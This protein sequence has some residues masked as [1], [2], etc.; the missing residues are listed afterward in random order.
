MGLVNKVIKRAL[1]YA[2]AHPPSSPEA[3]E[4]TERAKRSVAIS[5]AALD[6]AASSADDS[7]A[8]AVLRSEVTDRGAVVRDAID[9]LAN[10]RDNY[11]YDRAFRLLTAAVDGGPVRPIDSAVRDLFLGEQQLG[12]LPLED[13][14]ASLARTEP[15]L[16]DVEREIV[17]QRSSFEHAESQ[18][19]ARRVIANRIERLVGFGARRQG[20]LLRSDVTW[21]CVYGYL[22]AAA[23]AS[24]GDT[25]VALFDLPRPVPRSGLLWGLKRPA[26]TN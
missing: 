13:A 10:P 2:V 15:R 17:A 1:D 26:A 25:T 8:A 12:R 18:L 20:W 11:L 6:Q 22:L 16:R 23:G 21:S 4:R 24:D 9:A 3:L 5:Q 19:E 14:F 7:A